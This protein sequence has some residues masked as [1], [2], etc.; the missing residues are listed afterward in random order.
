M[1][2]E[3]PE[4]YAG[5]RLPPVAVTRQFPRFLAAGAVAAAA[6]FG[7]RFAFSLWMRFEWAVLCAFVVGLAIGFSLMRTYVFNTRGKSVG[8]QLGWFIAVNLLAAAQTFVISV[9]LAR[10]LLPRLNV[11]TYAEAAAH[12]VGVITPIVTSYVGHRLLTFR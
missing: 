8:S 7:S 11:H 2:N 6:N 1:S 9:V 10:W 12:L 4:F 3:D 5:A